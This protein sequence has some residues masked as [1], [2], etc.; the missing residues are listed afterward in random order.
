[1]LLVTLYTAWSANPVWYV[2]SHT[3][4]MEHKL[5]TFFLVPLRSSG[6]N[7][8]VARINPRTLVEKLLFIFLTKSSSFA[9]TDSG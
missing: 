3:P 4:R 6:R 5:A 8:F 1:M 7:A 2:T 9:L